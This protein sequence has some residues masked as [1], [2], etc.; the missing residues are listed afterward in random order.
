MASL[1][2]ADAAGGPARPGRTLLLL[3]VRAAVL[4][5]AAALAATGFVRLTTNTQNALWTTVPSW[6]GYDTAPAWW[7]PVLLLVGAGLCALFMRLPGGG[8][9]PAVDGFNFS[10]G[11][12][13]VFSVLGAGLATIA[14]GAVLGPCAVALAV[15]TALGY[16]ASWGGPRS[17]GAREAERSVLMLSGGLAA[18]SAILG[19]PLVLAL[20]MAEAGLVSRRAG[21]RPV[22]L[23]PVAVTLGL[24]YVVQVGIA[25]WPGLGTVAITVPDL[26]AY[27][28]IRAEDL[29][30]ALA[31][32]VV[33]ALL[34]QGVLTVGRR[35]VAWGSGRP[36]VLPLVVAALGTAGVTVGAQWLAGVPY[37]L[38]LFSGQD[39]I[40]TLFT[41]TS[42]SLVVV[43]VLAKTAAYALCVGAFRGG[44]V[45][46]AVTVGLGV[47]VAASQVVDGAAMP[48]LAAAAMAAATAAVLR[49]PFTAALLAVALTGSAGLAVTTPA[50]LGAVAGL[51]TVVAL[52]RRR[53][54]SVT[55]P[56]GEGDEAP[57]AEG[58]A[59]S[60]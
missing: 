2:G 42:L 34:M 49:L 38:V 23:A 44:P 5:P 53:S 36:A 50:L 37:D 31:L 55:G 54:E 56:A 13:E 57:A 4:G 29:G 32:G 14:F 24:A 59:G 11:L 28:D 60:V 41:E 35:L 18:F 12:R 19:N 58:R 48:A 40:P 22:A 43:A 51:V 9:P 3:L 39:A 26:P 6:M 25:D 21:V 7:V 52:D 17:G 27:T 46:P 45:F 20:L 10:V 33:V 15:G 8:G 16:V 30:L 1:A 47:A